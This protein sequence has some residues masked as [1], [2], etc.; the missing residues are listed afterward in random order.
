MARLH[1]RFPLLQGLHGVGIG[2]EGSQFPLKVLGF[3]GVGG[4]VVLDGCL[5]GGR[6]TL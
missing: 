3:F 1:V 5:R 4:G 2:Q 6:G